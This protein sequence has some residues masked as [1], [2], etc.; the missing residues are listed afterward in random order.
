MTKR[1]Y[2]LE[3][4]YY[5]WLCVSIKANRDANTT[6][7]ELTRALYNKD[8]KWHVPND[9]N[10]AIEARNLR[11]K[12]CE[13]I[14]IEYDY[15]YWDRP[16]NMLELIIALAYRCENIMVD[17]ADEK[18]MSDWF[19]IMMQNC[20]LEKFDDNIWEHSNADYVVEEILNKIINRKYQ[21]NGR[22]GLF[23]MRKDTKDQR[24]VELW[25]QMNTYLVENYY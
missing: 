18:E 8:F 14:G 17:M 22:G 9:D 12:F 19:W 15:E 24:K 10:R 1:V 6:Y 23:P 13:S 7:V 11:E 3:D 20:G 4:E 21:K 2:D 5:V 16:A 25:Y